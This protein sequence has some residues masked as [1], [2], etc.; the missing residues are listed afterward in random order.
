MGK[1]G[2][3]DSIL[4]ERRYIIQLTHDYSK[5][6]DVAES[7]ASAV[8]VQKVKDIIQSPLA[9]HELMDS[10]DRDLTFS[11]SLP[12]EPLRMFFKHLHDV[13]TGF[14]S[15][16]VKG[17]LSGSPDG[18]WNWAMFHEGV[19]VKKRFLAD[20]TVA[21][22]S[23]WKKMPQEETEKAKE[24]QK[25]KTKEEE[26][27]KIKKPD[28]SVL[29]QA[30]QK[31]A[32]ATVATEIDARLVCLTADGSHP[33]LIR[34]KVSSTRLYANLTKDV[35]FMGFYDVKNAKLLDRREDESIVQREPLVDMDQFGSFCDVANVLMQP[36]RDLVWILL[37]KSDSAFLKH[38]RKITELG[39]KDKVLHLVYSRAL[40]QKL[41]VKRMRGMANNRTYGR[42]LICWKGRFPAGPPKERQFVDAGS[43]IYEDT[44]L[45]V[46]V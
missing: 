39:W 45:K 4:W 8:Q 12:N 38:K 30:F 5:M 29:L 21:Y 46:L 15:P 32:E 10:A 16:E 42:L 19:R 22:D 7:A 31:D 9:M 17:A 41:Y 43:A 14:Y 36:H 40:I 2:D 26:K 24:E 11:Q 33:E 1:T 34:E 18:K 37:G 28:R 3:T 27:E 44:M 6:F 35:R 13:F 25:E 20:F 23:L